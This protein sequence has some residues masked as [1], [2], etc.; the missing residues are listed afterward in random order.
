MGIASHNYIT[1]TDYIK[2]Y[3]SIAGYDYSSNYSV[4]YY[5]DY[6]G[7]RYSNRIRFEEYSSLFIYGFFLED[8]CI[9]GIVINFK[10]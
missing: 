8:D 10:E 6:N 2:K 5:L 4:R 1:L 3:G 9:V 7:Y